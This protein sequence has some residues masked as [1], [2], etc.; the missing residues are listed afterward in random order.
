MS[1]IF[2]EVDEAVRKD[3]VGQFWERYS[4]FVYAVIAIIIVGVGIRELLVWQSNQAVDT[5]GDEFDMAYNALNE[6]RYVEAIEDFEAIKAAEGP[7]STL[8]THFLASA[9]IAGQGDAAA[10]STDLQSVSDATEDSLAQFALLKSA[11]LDVSSLTLAELEQRLGPLRVSENDVFA[12]LADELLAA[13]AFQLGDLDDARKR[14][15]AL[16][17]MLEINPGIQQRAEEAVAVIDSLKQTS[18]TE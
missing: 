18:G 2:E 10:A 12:P 16:R 7:F 15:D 6:G 5:R 14:Y 13:R 9:R 17:L 4:V 8:A 3:R 1:D 11:Y